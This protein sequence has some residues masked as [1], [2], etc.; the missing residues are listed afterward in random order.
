MS[1]VYVLKCEHDKWWVGYTKC[2]KNRILKCMKN[3]VSQWT[4][5]HKPIEMVRF[6]SGNRQDQKKLTLEL[7]LEHGWRNVRGG[8]W[9]QVKKSKPPQIYIQLR[10]IIK[11]YSNNTKYHPNIYDSDGYVDDPDTDTENDVNTD[12]VVVT[13]SMIHIKI[14]INMC[15]LFQRNTRR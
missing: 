12:D 5:T 14:P 15:I 13:K 3:G 1:H 4:R 11:E 9:S 10:Q 6:I 7:M 2:S 8:P